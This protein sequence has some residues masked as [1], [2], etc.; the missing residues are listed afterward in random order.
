MALRDLD[1]QRVLGQGKRYGLGFDFQCPEHSNCRI[2]VRFLRPDDGGPP[3]GEPPWYEHRGG[4]FQ[5]LTVCTPIVHG[6][7]EIVILDGRVLVAYG[8]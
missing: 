7:A 1:P 2:V 8:D 6:D 5:D 4:T 3:V